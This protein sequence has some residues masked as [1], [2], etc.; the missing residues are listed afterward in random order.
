[1]PVSHRWMERRRGAAGFAGEEL[2]V[3]IGVLERARLSD[4]EP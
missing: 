3:V 1:M 2:M 4:A